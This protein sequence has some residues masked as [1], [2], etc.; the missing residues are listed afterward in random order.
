MIANPIG[1]IVDQLNLQ[2]RLLKNVISGIGDEAAHRK[3]E[4]SQNHAA[5]ITGH[6]VSSRYDL[7]RMIGINDKEPFPELFGNRK[8]IQA[9]IKYPS[10]N[11]LTNGWDEIGRK[12]TE[13]LSKMTGEELNRP[14]PFPLPTGNNTIFGFAAFISHH[15]AYSIGQLSIFRRFLGLSAMSYK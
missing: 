15:E 14:T 9:E 6:L 4:G 1:P 12:L 2:T 8:A 10:M 7:A 3:L 13:R 11:E 5:W